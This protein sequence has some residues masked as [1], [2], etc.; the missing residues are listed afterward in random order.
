MPTHRNSVTGVPVCAYLSVTTG[1]TCLLTGMTA[2]SNKMFGQPLHS[3]FG[4]NP[5]MPCT[6]RQFSVWQ[7]KTYYSASLRLWI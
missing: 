1:K 3:E 4:K 6:N 5:P 7:K 2:E